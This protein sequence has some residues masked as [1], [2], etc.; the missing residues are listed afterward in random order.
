MSS[1]P[2]PQR[3][4]IGERTMTLKAVPFFTQLSDHELDLVRAVATEKTYPKNAVVLT[5]GEAGDSLFMI[6]AGKVKVFIGDEEGREIIL[7]ILGPG[8]FFGEMSMIDKQPRSASVTTLETSTFLVLQ[9]AAFEKCVEQAPTIGNM[10]MQV[11]AQ[12]VREADRKIGTL[13]LMDVYGRVASTLLELAVFTNGKLM[14]GEKLS[15]QDLAN[16]VGASREMVNRI[17]KDLSDR[18][19]ISIESKSITIINRELPPSLS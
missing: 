9:H 11:L 7:K 5:E 14:V 13:A 17:L 16:M 3:P 1:P 12:R 10:V 18:G 15:Q 19:F 4:N 6:Q 8:S 2:K